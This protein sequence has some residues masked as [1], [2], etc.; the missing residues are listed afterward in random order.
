MRFQIASA[1]LFAGLAIAAPSNG[2]YP[3]TTSSA[4]GDAAGA[5]NGQGAN[6]PRT[7]TILTTELITITSCAPT[8]TNCPARISSSVY[9]IVTTIPA[10]SGANGGAPSSGSGSGAGNGAGNGAG[11]GAGNGAGNGANAAGAAAGSG[12]PVG[13]AAATGTGNAAG[14]VGASTYHMPSAT[15]YAGPQFSGAANSLNAGAAL[16]GVGAFAALLL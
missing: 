2:T 13:A 7:S 6:G 5:I 4:G 10:G 16:A 15:G 1:A 14:A 12:R 3:S 8:V 11:S 9:P